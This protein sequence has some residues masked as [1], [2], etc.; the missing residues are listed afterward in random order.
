MLDRYILRKHDLEVDDI[1]QFFVE[2]TE[3]DNAS[4]VLKPRSCS[5]MTSK[6]LSGS[7]IIQ[8]VE[9]KALP[10]L[11]PEGSKRSFSPEI[12]NQR[13]VGERL[14]DVVVKLWLASVGVVAYASLRPNAQWL[15]HV[16]PCN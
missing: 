7:V 3:D 11:R 10:G 16:C 1:V 14:S 12:R 8:R 2:S 5:M 4:Y 13:E 6:S 15:E 9:F